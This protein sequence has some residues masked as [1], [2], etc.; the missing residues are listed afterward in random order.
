[1]YGDNY[2]ELKRQ[3]PL[4]PEMIQRHIRV[5]GQSIRFIINN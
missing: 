1:M 4:T 2:E 3:S 5:P